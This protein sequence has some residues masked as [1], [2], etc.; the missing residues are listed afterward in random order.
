MK[1]KTHKPCAFCGTEFKLFKT[2]DKH[3]SVQCF[4]ADSETKSKAPRKKKKKIKAVSDSM[5]KKLKVY[6]E[7]RDEFMSRPENQICP[8]IKHLKGIDVPAT[9]LHHIRGRIG[10]NLTD[11]RYFLAVSRQGHTWIH[12]NPSKSREL[13]WLK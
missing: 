5:A 13:K 7:K 11:E 4:H 3:C 12:E 8:V 9:D 6:R 2:T 1:Q 10:S